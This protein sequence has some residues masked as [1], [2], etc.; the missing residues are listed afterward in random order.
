M[1]LASETNIK[2]RGK[3]KGGITFRHKG[4]CSLPPRYVLYSFV[5]ASLWIRMWGFGIISRRHYRG[6]LGLC[7]TLKSG[8]IVPD[9]S[10]IW[11]VFL[12]LQLTQIGGHIL[13]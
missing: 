3:Q 1:Q 2:E 6:P 7:T 8:Y 12:Q 5:A 4:E 9:S 13:A 10:C 11:L